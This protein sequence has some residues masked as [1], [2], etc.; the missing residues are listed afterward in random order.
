MGGGTAEK[1][2]I[3]MKRTLCLLLLVFASAAI[4]KAQDK[5]FTIDRTEGCYTVNNI[6]PVDGATLFLCTYGS[7]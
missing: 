5:V 7:D 1:L 4:L 6:V 3:D 2:T